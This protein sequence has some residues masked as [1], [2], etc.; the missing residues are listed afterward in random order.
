[1]PATAAAQESSASAYPYLHAVTCEHFIHEFYI[2]VPIVDLF[3]FST[4][5][6]RRGSGHYCFPLS[7]GSC[8]AHYA[9]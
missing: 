3:M 7:V 2:L 9:A 5:S 6:A 1:M 4:I 8:A